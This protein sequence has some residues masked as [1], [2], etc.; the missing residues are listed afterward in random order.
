LPQR[1]DAERRRS[2]RSSVFCRHK[3]FLGG[4]TGAVVMR[5][6]SLVINI[7]I[8]NSE[9]G[10]ALRSVGVFAGLTSRTV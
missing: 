7:D 5:P 10:F 4:E 2:D 1:I 6:K 8:E 9:A 3:E